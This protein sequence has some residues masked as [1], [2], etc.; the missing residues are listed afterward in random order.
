M[1]RIACW[2]SFALL[3]SCPSFLRGAEEWEAILQ[4]GI[5]SEYSQTRHDALKQVDTKTVK[6]LKALWSVLGITNPDVVDW[7]VRE[8]AYEALTEAEGG[9]AEAEIHRLLTSKS[10]AAGGPAGEVVS[11]S[12]LA[13]EA[14]VYSVIWKIRKDFIKVHGE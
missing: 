10:A 4:Q 13:K 11:G 14:V 2:L 9:E 3:A 5:N 1:R 7:Y 12:D 6:G 8:G